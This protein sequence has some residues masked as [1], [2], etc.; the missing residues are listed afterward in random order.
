[1][2]KSSDNLS[3]ILALIVGILILAGIGYMFS[4]SKITGQAGE[5]YIPS[6]SPSIYS[7]LSSVSMNPSQYKIII[8]S[9]SI[10][11][12]S[13]NDIIASST[14]LAS[15][16]GISRS[17]FEIESGGDNRNAIYIV[18]GYPY[19]AQIKLDTTINTLNLYMANQ[20]DL[21]SVIDILSDYK[22]RAAELSYPTLFVEGNNL[23][24]IGCGTIIDQP[25]TVFTLDRDLYLSSMTYQS[26]PCLTISADNVEL[27]CGGYSIAGGITIQ[28]N[29]GQILNNIIIRDCILTSLKDQMPSDT[30]KIIGGNIYNVVLSGDNLIIDNSI[31]NEFSFSNIKLRYTNEAGIIEFV[32]PLS[33]SGS[34]LSQSISITTDS[35]DVNTQQTPYSKGF[36]LPAT[37]TLF[38]ASIPLGN[39]VKIYMDGEEITSSILNY[40]PLTFTV[41]RFEKYINECSSD[42]DCTAKQKCFQ[43]TCRPYYIVTGAAAAGIYIESPDGLDYG[44]KPAYQREDG[45]YWI[46]H[47][48]EQ[49]TAGYWGLSNGRQNVGSGFWYKSDSISPVGT[50]SG[51]YGVGG[52]VAVS[53]P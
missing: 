20:F 13:T 26:S 32:S 47:F 53:E 42:V 46:W 52:T 5:F 3:V 24:S 43:Q 25:G 48:A 41:P 10:P 18:V 21:D 38:G 40:N 50:Y 16:L 12:Y 15:A 49:Y 36:N 6:S 4:N 28:S 45:A 35:V 17:S 11:G 14:K 23:Y 30:I 8:P 9:Y 51:R 1:M 2:K 44:D 37:I 33:F 7:F 39:N 34:G 22:A 27:N 31:I 19:G 29:S